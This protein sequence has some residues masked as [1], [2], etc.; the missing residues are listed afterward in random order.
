MQ[1]CITLLMLVHAESGK[2]LAHSEETHLDILC[3]RKDRQQ[4]FCHVLVDM[5]SAAVCWAGYDPLHRDDGALCYWL[6]HMLVY[7]T[8]KA[9]AMW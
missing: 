1:A 8:C 7:N 3:L 4:V 5:Q 6:R 9:I 2:A